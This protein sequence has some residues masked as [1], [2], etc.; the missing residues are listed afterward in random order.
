MSATPQLFI[1][2]LT[3]LDNAV[4]DHARGLVGESWLVDVVLKGALNDIGMV[5]DFAHVK[6]DVKNLLE[7]YADHVLLV[8]EDADWLK[9]DTDGNALTLTATLTNGD[10]ITHTSPFTAVTPLPMQTITMDAVAAHLSEWLSDALE[11]QGLRVEVHLHNETIAGATYHY[12]HGLKKH[13]GNCQRIAHGHR[14]MLEIYVDGA[15]DAALEAQWAATWKDIYVG[16][17]EDLQLEADGLYHFAHC[18]SQ[19][20]FSL[21]LPAA[22]C[23]LMATDSTVEHIAEHIAHALKAQKPNAAIRVHAYEGV[24]K[25]A[26]AEA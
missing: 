18:S 10:V 25:G 12:C 20:E 8:P 23:T 15:R 17:K 11:E 2:E 24:R 4:L 5:M 22:R 1:K 16:S 26:I 6:H 14:S 21:S 3:V 19:G 9:S 13:D 7:A